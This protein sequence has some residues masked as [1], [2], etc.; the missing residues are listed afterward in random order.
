MGSGNG[1]MASVKL[2]VP[3]SFRLDAIGKDEDRVLR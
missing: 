2:P 3:L 1:K